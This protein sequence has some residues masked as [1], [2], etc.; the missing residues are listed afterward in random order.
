MKRAAMDCGSTSHGK[1]S[2]KV[3]KNESIN[4]YTEKSFKR[5]I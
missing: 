2:I 3:K 4:E 1:T 5:F